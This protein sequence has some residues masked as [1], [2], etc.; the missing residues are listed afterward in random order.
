MS[1]YTRVTSKIV[2]SQPTFL[3]SADFI[4]LAGKR[5]IHKNWTTDLTVRF[6]AEAAERRL[7]GGENVGVVLGAYDLVVDVDPRNGGDESWLQLKADLNIDASK[8]PTVQTGSGGL[9]VYMRLPVGVGRLKNDLS[10]EGY[11]GV[12]LKCIGRQVVAPGSRHPET[13]R[14]YVVIRDIDP[15]EDDLG[16][17]FAPNALIEIGKKN[18]TSSDVGSGEKSPEWLAAALEHLDV[19]I[20]SG[21]HDRWLE[22]M[23]AC[24][25]AT[26]GAACDE[27]V[28]WSIGDSTYADQ[29]ADIARRWDGL[30]S[31][32]PSRVTVKTLYKHFSDA[33]VAH[34][35]EPDMDEV[36][37]D[38]ADIDP[39]N[40]PEVLAR[41]AGEKP[42]KARFSDGLAGKWVW[43][44]RAEHFISRSD[45]QRFATFQFKA[46]YQHMWSDG[47][48]LSAVWKGKLPLKKFES[49]AYVPGGPEVIA[50]GKWTGHYNTW[51][52]GGVE[53][54]RN[55]DLA[56]VFIEHMMYLLPDE[57]ERGYALDYLSFLVRDDF[58]KVH[59]ALL[60]QGAPGTGKSFIGSVVERMIGMRN[61]RMV[62]SQ[63]LTKEYTSWQEDRQLAIVEEIMARGRIE[64]V[65]ELKT[66]IT[67]DTLRIRRMRTD[68]YE[69]PNGLNL[70]C[71]TNHENA[72]PIENGD[73]RWLTLFS[74][75][76]P[77]PP[78]YYEKL[79]EL[80]KGDDFA[81]AVKWMLQNRDVAL[82]PKGMAPTTHGKLEMRRRS[83]GEL[84]QYFNDL[85]D[86]G[87][88]N[89]QFD[90]VRLDDLWDL[91]RSNFRGT[92][93]LR[94]KVGDW[95]KSIGAVQHTS[96]KKQDTSG[97]PAYRL[98]SIRNHD[99]WEE[100][101]AAKRID[102]YLKQHG[103]KKNGYE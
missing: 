58:V 35:V 18:V 14:Q 33:G 73:R 37:N 4:A 72:V 30:S 21:D 100:V 67:G 102:A 63:E 10:Q 74:P 83:T 1:D 59:F 66:V 62:K 41:I 13:G 36:C 27:F 50:E 96:Y 47:D 64:L 5:P 89:F 17:P 55:D 26:A 11:P 57:T 16:L 65:N 99:E 2:A 20:Y 48:I 15:L 32:T 25:D 70:L 19:S 29:A 54:C 75:A 60:L 12:E 92:R 23:M 61:T 93:D 77:S 45:C 49:C 97:R 95:L 76:K 44:T 90:L 22:L 42:I 53:A 68:T 98:W 78:A 34:L 81:A 85:L 38:F 46:H 6:N 82:N 31:D 88:E 84:E 24:H 69:V 91:A 9:H 101:G 71:F 7:A 79:F 43:V 40:E 28:L 52:P 86:E 94:A 103:L 39:L 56:N 80:L 3:R 51:R 8:Y 87:S